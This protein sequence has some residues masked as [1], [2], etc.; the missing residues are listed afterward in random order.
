MERGQR[1]DFFFAG[2]QMSE[3]ARLAGGSAHALARGV[4]T[5]FSRV[6]KC[7]NHVSGRPCMRWY[8]G[9]VCYLKLHPPI[10]AVPEPPPACGRCPRLTD[11]TSSLTTKP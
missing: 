10:R 1:A 9:N 2:R 5:L 6:D 4:P 3:P 11:F 8:W 7:E